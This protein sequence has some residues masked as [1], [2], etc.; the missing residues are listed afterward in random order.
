MKK[1]LTIILIITAVLLG[2]AGCGSSNTE[3]APGKAASYPADGDITVIIP[4]AAGG[5]TDNS[6]RILCSLLQKELKGSRFVP[7]NKT[8]GGGLTGMTELAKAKPD[9]HTLGMVTVEL[10]MF[11][12]QGKTKLTYKDFVSVCAPVVTPAAL[13]VSG[14]APCYTLSEFVKYAKANP[15][16]IRMGNSGTGSVWHIAALN[17][18]KEFG[19]KFK[20]VPYPKGTADISAAFS[21]KHIDAA[22]AD[23]ASFKIQA[24]KGSVKILGIMADS[25]SLSLPGIPTFR[26]LG[27]PMTVRAWAVLAAPKDLP[28][29]K[30]AILRNAAENIGT[31]RKYKE[32]FRTEGIDTATFS[33]KECDAMMAKDDEMYGKL[34]KP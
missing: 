24:E 16:K 25:R 3:K 21:G 15:G 19:V 17:F 29:D 11:H 22:L 34:L 14:E 5:G 8:A 9:G 13:I 10:A 30:L 28:K 27:H 20:H 4:R 7:V 26:E 32:Q 33:G 18:E 2:V 1:L 6:A 12:H 31:K 23:P